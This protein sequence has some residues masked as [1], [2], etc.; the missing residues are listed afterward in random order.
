MLCSVVD[1]LN[2]RIVNNK[3]TYFLEKF[4][5]IYDY[6][7]LFEAIPIEYRNLEKR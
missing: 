1:T 3:E 5:T 2:C 6:A 4:N 7:I